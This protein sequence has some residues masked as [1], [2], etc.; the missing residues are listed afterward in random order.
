MNTN[1]NNI[2][3]KYNNIDQYSPKMSNNSVKMSRNN[4]CH[5]D[6]GKKYKKCCLKKDEETGRFSDIM[7]QENFGMQVHY[8]NECKLTFYVPKD[9]FIKASQMIFEKGLNTEYYLR[10][11]DWE[12]LKNGESDEM[13]Y[14]ICF[15]ILAAA[16]IQ[17]NDSNPYTTVEESWIINI[18]NNMDRIEVLG[19]DN[20]N[21]FKLARK[22]IY[23]G[24]K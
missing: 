13:T 6:S 11:I 12:N 8:N 14:T 15:H 3:V 9:R 22:F 20:E 16:F 5:C 4:K 2:N 19:V 24:R 21:W 17:K 18:T 23:R 10:R 7:F 1:N